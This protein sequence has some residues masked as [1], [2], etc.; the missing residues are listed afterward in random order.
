MI[1]LAVYY[2]LA[3]IVLLGQCLY[4]RGLKS[5]EAKSTQSA[6]PSSPDR[7]I[8]GSDERTAL[9]GSN[10]NA[11]NLPRHHRLSSSSF[12]NL[13]DVDGSHLSPVT[14]LLDAPKPT[15]PPATK[16]LHPTTALQSFIFNFF[17]IVLVCAAGV[18]GWWVS[19][20]PSA[21]QQ[22]HHHH[23]HHTSDDDRNAPSDSSD[24]HFNTL[25][26]IFGYLCALLY[27]GSRVP[28]LLLNYRRRSTEGVSMLF[29]LFACI[30]NLT[31]VM[32]IFAYSPVCAGSSE[33]GHR[34]GHCRD[35]EAAAQYARYIAVNA[36][37]IVGSLGTLFLDM[38]VFVQ[39]FI[40][41][42]KTEMN[43]VQHEG[44]EEEVE[45]EE[46]AILVDD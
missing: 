25:G 11:A 1:I 4:Y 33:G 12:R 5:S 19:N 24:L 31:Y 46:E 20:N 8:D 7:R 37:W 16:S 45:E 39:F 40:Y 22:Q 15:D 34:A 41:R 23:H 44:D 35:G 2:T 42:S 28:Q 26:Q 10:G 18:F 14:P 29:F 6:P 17:A 13:T 36:S 21:E 32:S 9:L 3:D 27:L 38:G 30:G 43:G